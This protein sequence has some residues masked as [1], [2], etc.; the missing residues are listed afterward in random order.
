MSAALSPDSS[1]QRSRSTGCAVVLEGEGTVM[2]GIKEGV[3]MWW[4]LREG[5]LWRWGLM[6][7]FLERR[8]LWR[9]CKEMGT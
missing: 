9:D 1:G 5:L 3:L 6:W 2:W 4:V 8:V 7:G